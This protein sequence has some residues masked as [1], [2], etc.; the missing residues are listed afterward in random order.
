MY[1]KLLCNTKG[2]VSCE[3]SRVAEYD[4]PDTQGS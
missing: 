1:Y 4:C 2:G 3:V